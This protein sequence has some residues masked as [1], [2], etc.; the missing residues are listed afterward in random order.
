M[1]YEQATK[2]SISVFLSYVGDVTTFVQQFSIHFIDNRGMMRKFDWLIDPVP[3]GA[4]LHN[5][6][7]KKINEADVFIAF[8]DKS[9][10]DKIGAEELKSALDARSDGNG[11]PLLIPIILGVDGLNWW[12]KIKDRTPEPLSNIVYQK[13]FHPGTN[14]YRTLTVEDEQAIHALRDW[15]IQYPW[16]QPAAPTGALQTTRPQTTPPLI[17]VPQISPTLSQIAVRPDDVAGDQGEVRRRVTV[18]F[19]ALDNVEAHITTLREFFRNIGDLLG[20]HLEGTRPAP[21]MGRR[22]E[23]QA[24]LRREGVPSRLTREF[25]E[26]IARRDEVIKISNKDSRNTELLKL[27]DQVNA[28]IE[29]EHILPASNQKGRFRF[30]LYIAHGRGADA[31]AN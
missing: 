30:L 22:E 11:R 29:R 24:E 25:V 14:R 23:I 10:P 13:F 31:N 4:E 1:S 27:A 21:S 3:A 8:V 19:E 16:V 15:V 6:L 7:V 5:E 12:T 20:R 2:R 17:S 9:Y 18:A 28:L 26:I